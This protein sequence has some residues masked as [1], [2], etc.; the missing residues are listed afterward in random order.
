MENIKVLELNHSY[1]SNRN[2]TAFQMILPLDCEKKIDS[3]DTVYSFLEVMEG[4]NWNKYLNHPAHRGVKNTIPFIIE[5]HV[6][7]NEAIRSRAR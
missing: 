4:A 1:L 7:D 2:D 3:F 5:N 6:F